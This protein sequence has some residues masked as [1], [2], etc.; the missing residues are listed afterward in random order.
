MGEVITSSIVVKVRSFVS[1][2]V[3]KFLQQIVAIH[4]I[5][6][7]LWSEIDQLTNLAVSATL[8]FCA[9]KIENG[10]LIYSLTE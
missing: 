8:I 3:T 9:E 5:W 6:L 7:S 4:K 2:W 1:S 10:L